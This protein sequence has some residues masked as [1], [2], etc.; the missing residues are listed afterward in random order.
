VSEGATIKN[1]YVTGLAQR[2]S[3]GVNFRNMPGETGINN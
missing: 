3:S 1:L 2:L